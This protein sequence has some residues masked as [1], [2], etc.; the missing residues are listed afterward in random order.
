MPLPIQVISH[1]VPARYFLVILRGIVLKGADVLVF[2]PQ[3]TALVIYAVVTLGLASLRL[4][5][6]R[7]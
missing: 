7:G 4:A 6:E 5:K 2:V 1:I 3:F